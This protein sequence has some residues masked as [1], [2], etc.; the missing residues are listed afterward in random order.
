MLEKAE[1]AGVKLVAGDDYGAEGLPHGDYAFRVIAANAEK[2]PAALA[3]LPSWSLLVPGLLLLAGWLLTRWPALAGT[4]L[5]YA[6]EWQWNV[7][8][9]GQ[10]LPVGGKLELGYDLLYYWLDDF[11]F[12][13]T[14]D[15]LDTQEAYGKFNA[16]ISLGSRG[17][18]WTVSLIGKNLAD[19]LTSN[20]G[21]STF[22]IGQAGDVGTTPNYKFVEPGR[23]IALQLG[24]RF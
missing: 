21:D 17:G 6:S 5:A 3:A 10:G 20:L 1:A 16:S 2:L 8:L 11:H 13:L 14:N 4:P 24:Y 18:S 19:K 12:K 23:Q 15:P 9:A 7:R 22:G